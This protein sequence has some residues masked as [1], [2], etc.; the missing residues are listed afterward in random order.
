LKVNKSGTKTQMPFV[1]KLQCKMSK[2][3]FVREWLYVS[4]GNDYTRVEH[5]NKN[6]VR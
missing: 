4:G 3:Y 5:V 1:H 6:E 2:T